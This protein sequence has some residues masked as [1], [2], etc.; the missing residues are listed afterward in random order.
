MSNLTLSRGTARPWLGSRTI[1]AIT[2]AVR[3]LA[4]AIERRRMVAELEE[5]DDRTLRDI[6][7]EPEAIRTRR[8]PYD[9][10]RWR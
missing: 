3:A 5:L 8:V 4:Q 7:I 1:G 2:G 6:G 10:A 9:G